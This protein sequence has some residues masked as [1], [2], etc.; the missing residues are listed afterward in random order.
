MTGSSSFPHARPAAMPKTPHAR[1]RWVVLLVDDEP[2][3]HEITK[4]VL[5]DTSFS[6]IPVELHSAYSALEARLFL[7]AH[8]DTALILLDV[9]METDDAGLRLV[10]YVREQLGNTDLQIVVRTGQPGMAPEREV[11]AAYD[12]NGYFLKTEMVAQKLQS[13][14]I[15]S[16][17]A[18]SYIRTLR[19]HDALPAIP[20]AGVA[21]GVQ[22]RPWEDDFAKALENDSLHLLAQP[23]IHLESGLIVAIELLPNWRRGEVILGPAQLAD[24]I[25]DPELRLQFGAW[26]LRKGCAW[27]RSW[28]SL[29]VPPFRVSVPAFTESIWDGGIA[30]LVAQHPSLVSV[31]R[32]SLDVTVSQTILR[33]D[34][35]S[36]REFVAFMQ[37]AGISITLLD[38]GSGE[39]SLSQ[40]QGLLPDR[41]KIHQSFVRHVSQD[42]GR[43][44]IA[45]SII[46]LA[47]TL[48][49]TVI[50][51]GVISED[52]L[53][54]FKWEGCD[55]G[56]GDIIAR[57]MA[58][59]DVAS[60]I[61]S[62]TTPSLSKGELH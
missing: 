22:R 34:V 39:L 40:L 56:Q 35:T 1:D 49:L 50:A 44:S 52:D 30:S 29:G 42:Q 14:V 18:Y 28:Q 24:E 57:P 32:G 46:A 26:L 48:G 54:F 45:R 10:T 9:V 47:H 33:G 13:I 31:P 37:S 3:V 11:I 53:Q 12:V 27:L 19:Q 15:S 2:E 59:S 23:Q 62:G 5:S 7:E 61:C 51:D 36:A 17:R 21:K 58:V 55:I 25:R 16:L 8:P 4:L 6:G 20:H 41:V 43:S 60:A 38:F